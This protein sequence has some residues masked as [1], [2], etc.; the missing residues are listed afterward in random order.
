[1]TITI[2]GGGNP[3]G[4]TYPLQR[5][6]RLRSS[7]SAYFN[8][9]PSVAGNQQRFT[10][11]GWVKLGTI[12]TEMMFLDAGTGNTSDFRMNIAA[13]GVLSV[14]SYNG[15][16]YTTRVE[17][18]AVLRDPSSWYHIVFAIDTTQ[19]TASNRV[20]IYINGVC[21]PHYRKLHI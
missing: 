21:K 13:T 17:T 9:T 18:S 8:R 15:V 14:V 6:V 20:L 2:V 3:S 4:P 1:M 11:S 12:S 16:A 5:S 19:A 7:A 10:W